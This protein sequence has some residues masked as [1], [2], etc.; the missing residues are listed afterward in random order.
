MKEIKL[1][2]YSIPYVPHRPEN[3]LENNTF[4]PVV[5]ADVL[6]IAPQNI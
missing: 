5:F 4:P 3:G 6:P 2:S 1:K